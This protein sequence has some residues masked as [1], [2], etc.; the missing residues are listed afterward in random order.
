MPHVHSHDILIVAVAFAAM[1]AHNRAHTFQHSHFVRVATRV[2]VANATSE[3]LS[4]TK[5]CDDKHTTAAAA[6][7]APSARFAS[8]NN[9]PRRDFAVNNDINWE[10]KTKKEII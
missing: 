8:D 3:F 5:L 7:A 2:C 10:R 9:W 4:T 1:S 6:A